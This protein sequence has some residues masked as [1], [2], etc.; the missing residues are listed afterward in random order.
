MKIRFILTLAILVYALK[1][2]A[3]EYEVESFE[4][5]PTDLSARTLSRIDLNGTPCA[6]IKVYADDKISAVRGSV[7]GDVAGEGMEKWVYV[8]NG[9]KEVE[10]V[11][12]KHLPLHLKFID[13]N[14]P[15][16]TGQMTYVM[17]LREKGAGK[18]G[19]AVASPNGQLINEMKEAFD[20]KD[21]NKVYQIGL[22]LPDDADAQYMMGQLYEKGLG[23]IKNLD[24]AMKLYSKASVQHHPAAMTAFGYIAAAEYKDY[25]QAYMLFQ[26]A[27]DR[28][29]SDAMVYLSSL[30][31]KGDG[32]EKDTME[33]MKWLFKAADAGNSLAMGVVAM[34][35]LNGYIVSEDPAEAMKWLLKAAEQNDSEAMRQ[36]AYLYDEGVGVPQSFP[37][38][39]KW[40]RK[41]ADL[42]NIQAMVT[43]AEYYKDGAAGRKD[44]KESARWLLM[45]AEN[46]SYEAMEKLGNYYEKGWGVTK[47]KEEALKWYRKAAE[48]GS[49]FAEEE[50]NRLLSSKS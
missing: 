38:A 39:L 12:E 32:V 4:I 46:G 44:L 23:V 24:E 15:S 3:Q 26:E 6:I 10:L 11:F 29:N 2:G 7:I 31:D 35:Y 16:L 33:S 27:A 19:P 14:Y 8:T 1:T 43:I 42:G 48:A 30:Y 28:G 34:Y 21:Y 36:I 45:A 5:V 17:H 20:G 18:T 37:N 41:A 50:Y 22:R 9:A 13:Y 47:S 49:S 40:L 25:S